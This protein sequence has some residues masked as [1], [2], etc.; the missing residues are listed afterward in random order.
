MLQDLDETLKQLLTTKLPRISTG[1]VKIS[2]A[3]PDSEFA[4]NTVQGL[5]INL[6]L[7]DIRENLELRSNDWL[8]QRQSDGTALKYQ[9]RGV[10]KAPA[11][12]IF[13][14]AIGLKY[15]IS[16][17]YQ[18]GLNPKGI[19]CIRNSYLAPNG[20]TRTKP[21]REDKTITTI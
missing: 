13:L 1:E 8:V 2:F 18:D 14:G 21:V 5:T 20:E 19:N 16:K 4:T 10:H 6:F 17:S 3:A 11:N 12:E 15:N 9:P 7:H